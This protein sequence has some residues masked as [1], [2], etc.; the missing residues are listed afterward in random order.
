MVCVPLQASLLVSID[1]HHPRHCLMLTVLPAWQIGMARTRPRLL[2]AG[3][4]CARHAGAPAG[5]AACL[6]ATAGLAAG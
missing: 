6:A 4:G 3:S 2:R 1:Q 5:Q